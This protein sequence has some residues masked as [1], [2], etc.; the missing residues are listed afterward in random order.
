MWY[1][2]ISSRI[3]TFTTQLVVFP[4]SYN[5][6]FYC[7]FPIG[8]LWF[9]YRNTEIFI[10]RNLIHTQKKNYWMRAEDIAPYFQALPTR[11]EEPG[12]VPSTHMVAHNLL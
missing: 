1:Y 5:V 4:I 7:D 6:N 9:T 12:L 8:K 3:V 11:L 10:V 2:C